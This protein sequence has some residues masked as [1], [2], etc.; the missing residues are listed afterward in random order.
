V[1][2]GNHDYNNL[3]ELLL[4]ASLPIL[5]SRRLECSEELQLK[6][7]SCAAG[8]NP[9]LIITEVCVV[10]FTSLRVHC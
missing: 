3:K 2:G 4:E 6:N 9:P 5:I 1:S 8:T 7:A 10:F